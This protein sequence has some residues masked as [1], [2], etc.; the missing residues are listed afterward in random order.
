MK[1]F[2]LL[3]LLIF[4]PHIFGQYYDN[5]KDGN[6]SENPKWFVSDLNAMIIRNNGVYV[7]E[8]TKSNEKDG[9][10]KTTNYL[11]SNT[12][13]GCS[14]CFDN[15]EGI[16]GSIDFVLSAASIYTLTAKGYFIRINTTDNSIAFLYRNDVSSEIILAKS[17]S[18]IPTGECHLTLKISNNSYL[19]IYSNSFF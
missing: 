9:T 19:A 10:F 2:L 11:T 1:Y 17:N 13:W 12:E 8:L 7:A 18:C 3:F 6:Y 5:F 14:I 16:N 15:S 4:T